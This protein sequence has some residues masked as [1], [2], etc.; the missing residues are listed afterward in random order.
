MAAGKPSRSSTGTEPEFAPFPDADA[1]PE[2]WDTY[3]D[4]D[5]ALDAPLPDGWQPQPG[6]KLIGKITELDTANVGG[7]G[8]YPLVTVQ[9]A[10]GVTA[11]HAFH[12]T[13]SNELVRRKVYRR[14]D[15]GTD[16]RFEY[17]PNE[18]FIGCGIGFKYEGEVEAKTGRPGK[19][20]TYHV[21]RV[22]VQRPSVSS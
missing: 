16:G 9:T 21:Y 3:K 5:E 18:D 13:I 7:F 15:V 10:D 22:K 2:A 12:D 20:P 14:V 17:V 8:D 1:P 6:D 4:L 11:V 19:N